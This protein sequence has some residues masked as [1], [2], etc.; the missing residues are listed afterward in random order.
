[1]HET[2][3]PDIL[4]LLAAAVLVVAIFRSL[5]LSP[6]LGY[7]VAGAL[8]GPH[9]FAL[10][11]KVES[12]TAIAELGV[13]LLLFMIG[14]ELS[15]DRLRAMR[16]QVFGVGGLQVIITATLI[17][18]LAY[19][20]NIALKQALIIGAGLALS[21]TALVLQVLQERHELATQTGRLSLAILILQD[22]A[23]LPILVLVPLLS[24]GA[25][26]S[27]WQAISM[28]F[29]QAVIVLV[30]IIVVGRLAL[31]PLFRL[32]AKLDINELFVATTLLVVLGISF[33]TAAAGLSLALGAFIAGLLIAETEFQHQIEADV[34]PYKGLLMG[35]FFMSVGMVIDLSFILN[36][37][38]AV[39]ASAMALIALKTAII[40]LVLRLFS[41]AR[42][43]AVHVALL[44]SQG[45]EFG[46]IL[47]GLAASTG[48]LS[49]N[50]SQFLLLVIALTMG[51]TPLLERL[52]NLFERAWARRRRR[53]GTAE[54]TAQ[55]ADLAAHVV[56]AGYGK[57][58]ELIA[59]A[60]ARESI[61]FIALDTDPKR[62]LAGRR[63]K[64]PVYFGD[65]T[66]ADVLQAVGAT[67]SSAII[68]SFTH[69]AKAQ[70]AIMQLKQRYPD[71]PIFTRAADQ[72]SKMQLENMG[73]TS[74]TAEAHTTCMTLVAFTL[75]ALGW[76]EEEIA[77]VMQAQ[78][79]PQN[80][81]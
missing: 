34:K 47:F 57:A 51:L 2:P 27:L 16:R 56:I 78:R 38:I 60:F 19:F 8:I 17:G 30:V 18:A 72:M 37:A 21:S 69:Y 32:I 54:I 43:T 74:S 35:L 31:R 68:L 81:G 42:R 80:K 58:G 33:A 5:R 4:L 48:V 10:V 26:S 65:A 63:N 70:Q 75:T 44:L 12:T 11:A 40:Y 66:R 36:H 41:Y 6:V 55:S 14:L 15:L 25:T 45:G 76:P 1:M 71:T 20:S 73:A 53:R 77:R 24:E 13:I 9:G 23:V 61:A 62:V 49:Q 22:L 67:R 39:L 29:L 64:H 3:L 52:G 50:T 28:A 59:H 7:L 46:F 79:E